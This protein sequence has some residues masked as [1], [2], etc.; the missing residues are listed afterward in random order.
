MTVTDKPV[1]ISAKLPKGDALNGLSAVHGQLCDEDGDALV[2]MCIGHLRLT[3]HPGGIEEPTT[4]VK[5]IE[6]LT[7][8]LAVK[9]GLLLDRARRRRAQ[10]DTEADTPSPPIPGLAL[11]GGDSPDDPDDVLDEHDAWSYT[12][13]EDEADIEPD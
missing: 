1:K 3:T 12:S 6:G 9:G 13:P 11:D 10:L 2:I 5:R 8:N 4:Y 7:G